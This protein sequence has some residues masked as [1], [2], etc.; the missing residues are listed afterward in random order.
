MG[1]TPSISGGMSQS[2]YQKLLDEQRKYSEEADV[3]RDAKLREY[4]KERL[5]AEKDLLE[6]AKL[7]EQQKITSQ[8]D[9]EEEIAEELEASE[10]QAEKDKSGGDKLGR[11]LLES[12]LR[13]IADT[14]TG[15]ERPK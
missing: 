6:S 2:E 7:A 1:G 13:G 14:T 3:K 15:Q 12:L 4:E 8:Q 5:A 9:A 11:S 10:V